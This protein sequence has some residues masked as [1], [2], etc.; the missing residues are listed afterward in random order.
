MP[1]AEFFRQK[2][3]EVRALIALAKTAEVR[4]QLRL[5]ARELEQDAAKAQATTPAHSKS[6]SRRHAS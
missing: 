5:W 6:R 1:T 4:A 2:A 3:R